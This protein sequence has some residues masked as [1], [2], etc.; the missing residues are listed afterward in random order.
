MNI[1]P[2]SMKKIYQSIIE[3][4]VLLVKEGKLKAG[5]KLPPERTLAEMFNVSRA[6][7]REAFSA[8]E[9][10]GLIEV[11][12]GEGT[13]I[14]D[15]NIAPFINAI[16]PLFV[17]NESMETDLLEF[18]T[19]LEVNAVKIAA[20]NAKNSDLE[21]L[22]K[23]LELMESALEKNDPVLGAKADIEFHKAIF[24]ISGNYI[25]LKASECM[26]YILESSIRFN[27]EKILY[28]RENT[29]ML[30]NQHIQIYEAIKN[31]NPDL[32]CDIMEKHLNLVRKIM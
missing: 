8:M 12:P 9:I 28:N 10:I 3:Q 6:S 20:N 31:N 13:F 15:L 14:S 32:A 17:K 27:R 26:T 30:L 19:L 23:S 25:L 4:I 16:A 21:L 24:L 29:K 5:D 1:N 11:R 22:K 7:I 18:R 2:I